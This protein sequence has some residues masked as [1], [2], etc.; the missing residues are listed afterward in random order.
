MGFLGCVS[1]VLSLGG[2]GGW[3][4]CRDERDFGYGEREWRTMR[5]SSVLTGDLADCAGSVHHTLQADLSARITFGPGVVL[6]VCMTYPKAITP[7]KI[8][9]VRC[10]GPRRCFTVAGPSEC[11]RSL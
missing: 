9:R 6:R 5:L 2:R 1:L 4:G 8:Q 10:A 3:E 11:E 7:I